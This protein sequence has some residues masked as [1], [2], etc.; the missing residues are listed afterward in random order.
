MAIRFI[1]EEKN[2]LIEYLWFSTQCQTYINNKRVYCTK[3]KEPKIFGTSHFVKIRFF[4][5][6]QGY[7]KA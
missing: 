3:R 1:V 7:F 6:E 2:G 5:I 4:G